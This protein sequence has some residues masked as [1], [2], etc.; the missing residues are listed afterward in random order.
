LES[1]FNPV[2]EQIQ[3]LAQNGLTSLMVL[4]D[5]LSKRIAP[6]QAHT[7]PA[8]VFTGVNDTTWLEHGAGSSLDDGTHALSLMKLTLDLF[9]A[10]LVTSSVACQP[11][12]MDQVAQTA[13]LRMMSTLDD[14]DITV[15][16]RGEQTHGV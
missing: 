16:Q 10:D 8:W 11:I 1:G 14:D 4:H 3:L 6:L 9:L 15:V 7:R 2:L 12:C 13:L 5:Y